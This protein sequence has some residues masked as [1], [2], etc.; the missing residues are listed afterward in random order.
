MN[1]RTVTNCDDSGPGSLRD[2]IF[3]AMTGDLID[4]TQLACSEITLYTGKIA[5]SS[6]DMTLLGPGLGPEASSHLT[7]HGYYDRIFT[8]GS[9]TLTISVLINSIT[10]TSASEGT[11]AALLLFIWTK[12]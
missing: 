8:Q 4:L 1:I 11:W 5:V 6:A 10:S 9:G 7:I 3:N 2:T 12:K